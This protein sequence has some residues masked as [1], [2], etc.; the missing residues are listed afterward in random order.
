MW[1]KKYVIISLLVLTACSTTEQSSD[2][3]STLYSGKPVE[4]LT[5]DE[6]PKTEEEAISRGDIA[7]SNK[8]VDLALYEYIRSLS[9]PNAVHKDKT[10]YTVGRIHLA[11]ENSEL[12]DKSFRA[13]LAENPDHIGSL[14]EL[15]TLYTKRGEKDVGKSYYIRA[16]NADQIRMDGD[17]IITKDNITA[18]SVATY[19]Y[20]DKSPVS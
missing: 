2:F 11:R 20:D 4:S 1:I 19:R 18:E 14:T 13:S 8:N 16:L 17:P 3:D 12:A 7:L 10:L 9:F 6:P 5:N 15:G